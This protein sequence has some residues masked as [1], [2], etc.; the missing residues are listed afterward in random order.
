MNYMSQKIEDGFIFHDLRHTFAS[1]M[2]SSGKITLFEL[3][4]L[5]NHQSITMTLR[6][7]HLFDKRLHEAAIVSDE[8]Y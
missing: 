1:H 5:M 3:Q 6:Y 4:K 8:I 2:A 7:A